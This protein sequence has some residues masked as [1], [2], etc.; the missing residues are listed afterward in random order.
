MRRSNPNHRTRDLTPAAVLGAALSQS[1]R[2]EHTDLAALER[3]P[4]ASRVFPREAAI[5]QI[6]ETPPDLYL[7]VSGIAARVMTTRSGERQIVALLLPGDVFDWPLYRLNSRLGPPDRAP[8]DHAVVAVGGCT[9]AM[10]RFQ[11]LR[12]TL[13]DFPPLAEAFERRAVRE[14]AIAREWMVNVGARRASV[15]LGHM[16]CEIFTR[17]RAM[18]LTEGDSC[19]LPITQIHMAEALGLSSVHVNREL[20]ALRAEGL[21]K[22]AASVLVLPDLPRLERLSDFSPVYLNAGRSRR[23][24]YET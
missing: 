3:I 13:E 15:R 22:L 2:L 18:G 24:A 23:W 20:Q 19:L 10:A 9:V 11:V 16:I 1:M 5:L 14:Q 6:G 12:K 4:F 8:L 17:L 21:L 7:M